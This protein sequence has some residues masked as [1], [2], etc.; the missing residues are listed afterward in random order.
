MEERFRSAVIATVDIKH[1]YKSGLSGLSEH[2]TKVEV[3]NT[4]E[5]GGSVSIDDCTKQHYPEANR[6]DYVFGYKGEAYFMEVHPAR[7]SE[8]S[9]VLKK[10]S[11][12]LT[13]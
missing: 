3:E 10:F 1:C 6:W 4:R 9:V 7:T 13:G 2:K 11:G 5:I 8:V 12:S